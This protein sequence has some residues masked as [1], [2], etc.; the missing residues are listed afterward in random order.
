MRKTKSI[1]RSGHIVHADHVCAPR[2]GLLHGLVGRL[3]AVHPGKG[4][5]K[6]P[7]PGRSDK[8]RIP[9]GEEGGAPHYDRVLGWRLAEPYAGIEDYPVPAY[10]RLQ[11]GF[12][13]LPEEI[14]D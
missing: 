7:L 1:D 8:D 11:R 6:E 5:G 14:T 4:L 9:F 13:P 12:R 10:A 3:V 2:D